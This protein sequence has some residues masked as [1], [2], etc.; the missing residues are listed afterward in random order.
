VRDGSDLSYWTKSPILT[1]PQD[2]I[3]GKLKPYIKS[4][5]LSKCAPCTVC[6]RCERGDFFFYLSPILVC[7]FFFFF[8]FCCCC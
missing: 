5:K 8:F 3:E 6:L 2:Y 7:F 4:Q 1:H